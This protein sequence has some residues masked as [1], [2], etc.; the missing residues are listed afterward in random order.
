MGCS[1]QVDFNK[2]LI[3]EKTAIRSIVTRKYFK[4]WSPVRFHAIIGVFFV[5]LFG[6]TNAYALRLS[7]W[8]NANDFQSLPQNTDKLRRQ[9]I[10]ATDSLVATASTTHT[11]VFPTIPVAFPT[12]TGS[13]SPQSDSE[14]VKSSKEAAAKTIGGSAAAGILFLIIL[15]LAF[16]MKGWCFSRGCHICGKT[17]RSKVKT[18]QNWWNKIPLPNFATVELS[19]GQGSYSTVELPADP[20]SSAQTVYELQADSID[21]DIHYYELSGIVMQKNPMVADKS[22][23]GLSR[24]AHEIMELEDNQAIEDTSACSRLARQLTAEEGSASETTAMLEPTSESPQQNTYTS[25]TSRPTSTTA[26]A[27]LAKPLR[28]PPIP[29]RPVKKP[30]APEETIH[31]T[32]PEESMKMLNLNLSSSSLDLSLTGFVPHNTKEPEERK[33]EPP[34]PPGQISAQEKSHEAEV[35]P[36]SSGVHPLVATTEI[37]ASEKTQNRVTAAPKVPPRPTRYRQKNISRRTTELEELKL[38]ASNGCKII[39]RDE[40]NHKSQVQS[41]PNKQD[42]QGSEDEDNLDQSVPGE[43]A[44]LFISNFTF[45]SPAF[46]TLNDV[47]HPP[48]YS[49]YIPPATLEDRTNNPASREIIPRP[50]SSS[51]ISDH[52][53]FRPALPPRPSESR[54]SSTPPL[55]TSP[56]LPIVLPEVVPSYCR[57]DQQVAVSPPTRSFKFP[58]LRPGPALQPRPFRPQSSL[59]RRPR[60]SDIQ[61]PS[62]SKPPNNHSHN[63]S[64]SWP[65]SPQRVAPISPPSSSLAPLPQ[66][67]SFAPHIPATN[68]THDQRM[69][70]MQHQSMQRQSIFSTPTQSPTSNPPI[71]PERISEFGRAVAPP[72]PPPKPKPKM[73]PVR[74]Y[75]A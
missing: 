31:L 44:P 29:P 55:P 58:R 2:H 10:G 75:F 36:K 32:S 8:E 27:T 51:T 33:R 34:K 15:V 52:P 74:Y 63:Y 12:I 68:L 35:S 3:R 69:V 47:V 71:S 73:E 24:K 17:G 45:S 62:R 46:A 37:E 30:E 23:E 57:S 66:S 14:Y 20:A 19:I 41:K 11:A 16:M 67:Q 54:G 49:K 22:R 13:I 6:L 7:P 43:S 28:P 50:K 61:S 65:S 39:A 18:P 56:Q 53:A 9:E 64:P 59:P 72:V 25:N 21:H 42:S 48:Q 38:A 5:S 60:T 40:V 26:S 4:P 70:L 1:V